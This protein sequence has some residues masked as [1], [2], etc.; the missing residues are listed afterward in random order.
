MSSKRKGQSAS[1]PALPPKASRAASASSESLA[2]R[3]SS[4]SASNSTSDVQ[5]AKD[6]QQREREREQRE[7][8]QREKRNEQASE[9]SGL[10]SIV[11]ED[12]IAL[13]RA[14]YAQYKAP[15]PVS[16]DFLHQPHTISLLLACGACLVY[17]AFQQPT[18]PDHATNVKTY[19][20]AQSTLQP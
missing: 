16:S 4:P 12:Q 15:D 18:Y 10:T 11:P 17:Y 5:R 6:K 14:T 7:R 2:S 8:E 20:M 13:Y 19:V 3:S 9:A 1:T